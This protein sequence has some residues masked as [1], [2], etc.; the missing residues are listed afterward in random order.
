MKLSKIWRIVVKTQED[1]CNSYAKVIEGFNPLKCRFMVICTP[2]NEM[3]IY[4]SLEECAC[5][6]GVDYRIDHITMHTNEDE[7]TVYVYVK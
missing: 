4:R 1:V 3:Q 2:N 6:D 7:F 5:Y